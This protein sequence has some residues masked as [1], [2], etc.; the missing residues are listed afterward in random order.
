MKLYEEYERLARRCYY[1][2]QAGYRDGKKYI[3]IF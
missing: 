3:V 1:R 2:E